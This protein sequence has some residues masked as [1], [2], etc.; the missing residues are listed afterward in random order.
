MKNPITAKM[1]R[2]LGSCKSDLFEEL[3]GNKSITDEQLIDNAIKFDVRWLVVVL[4]RREQVENYTIAMKDE[5]EKYVKSINTA[6]KNSESIIPIEEEYAKVMARAF[7][8]EW[9]S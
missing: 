2:Y 7:L 4:L 8:K 5:V 1:L 6:R 3:F 9:N